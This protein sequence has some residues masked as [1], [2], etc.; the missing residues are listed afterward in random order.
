MKGH[1]RHRCGGMAM[2]I[3]VAMTA[4]VGIAL[5]ALATRFATEA[6]MTRYAAQDAQVRQLLLAGTVAARDELN[7]PEAI[8]R[9]RPLT[10]RVPANPH[11]DA[12]SLALQFEPLDADDS[13]RVLIDA[14]VGNRHGRQLLRFES[15]AAQWRLVEADCNN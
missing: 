4:M 6:K 9:G 15:Q 14:R 7:Q 1:N 12:T 11:G 3:A 10:V 2:I 8:K 13:Q 5:L